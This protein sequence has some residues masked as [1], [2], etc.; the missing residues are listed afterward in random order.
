MFVI[1]L[2]LEKKPSFHEEIPEIIEEKP[3]KGKKGQKGKKGK[4]KATPRETPTETEVQLGNIDEKIV[5]L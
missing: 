2:V 3:K 5:H 4:K 1:S